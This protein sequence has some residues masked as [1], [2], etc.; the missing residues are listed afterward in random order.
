MVLEKY[1]LTLDSDEGS[2]DISLINTFEDKIGYKLPETYK[3]LL[4]QHNALSIEESC[5]EF[6]NYKEEKDIGAVFFEGFG[7]IPYERI[8]D[9]NKD[10]QSPDFYG[11]KELIVFGSS[12][13]GDIVCFDYRK[14]STS[15]TPEIAYI[16][17]E[18]FEELPDGRVRNVINHVANSFEDFLGI[19]FRYEDKYDDYGNPL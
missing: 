9:S 10:F 13:N 2:V 18:K 1:N 14:K 5:F 8:E 4:S 3:K 17:H 15:N 19:L 11:E 7:E 6:I 16:Y 12:G